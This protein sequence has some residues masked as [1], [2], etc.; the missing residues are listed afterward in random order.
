MEELP[1]AKIRN[2]GGKL[3]AELQAYGCTTAGQVSLAPRDPTQILATALPS[4]E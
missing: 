2:F 4:Q 3:G 1:L